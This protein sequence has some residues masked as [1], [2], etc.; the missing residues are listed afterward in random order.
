MSKIIKCDICGNSGAKSDERYILGVAITRDVCKKCEYI[1]FRTP[2]EKM[3]NK[4]EEFYNKIMKEE[5]IPF[6]KKIGIK[7]TRTD[8]KIGRDRFLNSL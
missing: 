7:D 4:V 1:K 3:E 2:L 8:A 5:L 6:L